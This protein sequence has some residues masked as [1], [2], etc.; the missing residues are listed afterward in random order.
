MNDNLH[1]Q[2]TLAASRLM[3]YEMKRYRQTLLIVCI[4]A[5]LGANANADEPLTDKAENSVNQTKTAE[6]SLLQGKWEGA[7][8]GDQARQKITVTITGNS[9]DFH[10]D[11]DFWFKTKV[12]LPTGKDPKQLHATIK[13]CPASQKDSIGEVV[14]A[15]FELEDETLILATIGDDAEE[16][17]E[18]FEATKEQGTR[19]ELR[20]VKHQKKIERFDSS[21]PTGSLGVSPPMPRQSPDQPSGLRSL[22]LQGHELHA[23][24]KTRQIDDSNRHLP[25]GMV[26]PGNP[27]LSTDAEFVEAIARSGSQTRLANQARKAGDPLCTV[28]RL[29]GRRKRTRFLWV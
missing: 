7:F 20:K 2:K 8:M 28:R 4:A 1:F 16:T 10:R 11:K 12:T 27:H 21:V 14:R 6:L 18:S 24:L 26:P 19:Y 29:R 22:A 9:L 13:G 5:T 15:F 17:L 3:H 25:D 23:S